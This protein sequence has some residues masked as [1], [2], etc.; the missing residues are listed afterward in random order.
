MIDI[1]PERQRFAESDDMLTIRRVVAFAGEAVCA[2]VIY[3]IFL[4]EAKMF[5]ALGV[6][7]RVKIWPHT[8]VV[9]PICRIALQVLLADV[10]MPSVYAV[11]DRYAARHSQSHFRM[12]SLWLSMFG[13]VL[14]PIFI[15]LL[16]IR[17][18]I[19]TTISIPLEFCLSVLWLAVVLLGAASHQIV[20]QM[21]K[22]SYHGCEESG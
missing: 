4:S 3:A 5:T 11:V 6:E 9:V 18:G 13:H 10:R 16:L 14:S 19:C 15:V 22:G 21:V 2:V 7:G 1:P 8:V 17:T 20:A 12:C